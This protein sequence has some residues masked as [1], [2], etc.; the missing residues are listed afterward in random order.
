MYWYHWQA[1]QVHGCWGKDQ[2]SPQGTVQSIKFYP[3]KMLIKI[4]S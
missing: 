2:V 3:I 4:D 1:P